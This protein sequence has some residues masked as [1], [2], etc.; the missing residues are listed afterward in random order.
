MKSRIMYMENKSTG[1]AIIGRIMTK[2]WKTLYYKGKKF[3][4]LNKG[5]I[6]GNYYSDKSEYWISG[7]HKDG[8][9]RLWG[10]MVKVDEDVREE[11]WLEIRKKPELINKTSFKSRGS[12]LV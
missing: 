7:C 1:E 4:R 9:D 5:G 2:N 10:G 3:T 12:R 6:Y 8:L 11:Y